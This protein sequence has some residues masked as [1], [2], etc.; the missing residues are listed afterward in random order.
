MKMTRLSKGLLFALCLLAFL[1]SQISNEI[2]VCGEPP[3]SISVPNDY[4]TIQSAINNAAS[5]DTVFVSAGL[6]YERVTVNKTLTLVGDNWETVLDG[7]NTGTLIRVT[8]DNVKI[9]GFKLQNSGWKW[10]RA[11]VEVYDADN[12]VIEDNFVYLTC[13]QIRLVES[14]GSKVVSNIVS[15]PSNPFPQ[16]AYGIRLENCTDCLVIDNDVSNNIGGIHFEGSVNCTVTRN[17]VFQNSQGIRLYSPCVNN[18]IVGNTVFNNTNDGMFVALPDN[19]T[20]LQNM[21]YHNNFVNNSQPFIGEIAGCVWD[22]G[23][24]GNYWTAYQGQDNSRDGIGDTPHVFGEERDRYPLMGRHFEYQ[25]SHHEKTCEVELICNFVVL[26]FHYNKVNDSNSTAITL[27]MERVAGNTLF[28]RATFPTELLGRPYSVEVDGSRKPDTILNELSRSNSTHVA[29]YFTH[30]G[31][32]HTIMLI[33]ASAAA[34]QSL[35]IPY[36]VIAAVLGTGL[37]VTVLILWRGRRKHANE[38]RP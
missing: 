35:T 13:H 18:K 37:A 36:L 10:G 22:N 29:L 24:E 33:G 14:Q 4:P 12:C 38:H 27:K 16:S 21:F 26:D 25:V 3:L 31:S 5:G 9:T 19:T 34:D 1:A 23:Y 30:S 17:Y 6:Y 8:A 28:C 32:A 7:S 2:P 20:F 11:G 15:A